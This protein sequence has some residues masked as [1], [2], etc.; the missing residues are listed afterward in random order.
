MTPPYPWGLPPRAARLQTVA[1]LALFYGLVYGSAALTP[2]MPHH[3]VTPM[4][5]VLTLGTLMLV[6]VTVCCRRDV[7]WRGSLG[8]GRLPVRSVAAWGLV[9]FAATY[10]VNILLTFGYVLSHGG[11][12]TQVAGRM[13]SLEYLAEIPPRWIVPLAA[14]VG[15]WEETVFR[16]FLLGR[17]RA[18]LPAGDAPRARLRRDVLAVVV[19]GLCFGAGHGYQG[20]LG[21]MQTTMAGTVL[22]ALTLWRGSVWPAI[23]AHLAIDAFGLLMIKFVARALGGAADAGITP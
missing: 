6:A 3:T 1:V 10:G 22:G 5:S 14:F 23:G 21:L 15:L 11:L 4:L 7:S 2:V 12:E 18:A 16:G 17:L 13:R 19:C 9:A 8:L 20:A